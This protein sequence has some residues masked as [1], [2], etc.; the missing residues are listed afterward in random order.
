MF[1]P[2]NDTN[3]KLRIIRNRMC[4][5]VYISEVN[6]TKLVSGLSGI[7]ISLGALFTDYNEYLSH[8][9][10]LPLIP[11]TIGEEGSL[12]VGFK[13]F[14]EV[15]AQRLDTDGSLIELGNIFI[16]NHFNNFA[17]F[18]GYTKI[19]VYLPYLGFVDVN[20]NDVMG[21]YLYFHISIN[22]QTGS[23]TY[24]L[25]VNDTHNVRILSTHISQIGQPIPI[26]QTNAAEISRNLAMGGVKALASQASFAIGNASGAYMPISHS[27]YSSKSVKTYQTRNKDTNRLRTASKSTKE[28]VGSSTRISDRTAYHH[29]LA[30][31]ETFDAAITALSGCQMGVS[32]DRPNDTMSL[33]DCGT[34]IY[35][36]IYRPKIVPIDEEYGKLYGYP[37]GSV[38]R[39]G[40]CEGYTEISSVHLEGAG[41]ESIT[42]VERNMILEAF[43]GGVILPKT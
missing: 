34:D 10:Y 17:D 16:P 5:S 21:K 39:I 7:D 37:V 26:G 24:I 20:T 6:L 1:F 35:V 32:M 41:F 43:S 9:V 22:Y 30:I 2:V 14:D 28:N 29:Q 13:T 31:N 19:S 38:K 18:N 40:E 36:V 12:S 33:I 27:H 25:S 15:K 4:N 11:A 3:K 8:L 23:A 42:E